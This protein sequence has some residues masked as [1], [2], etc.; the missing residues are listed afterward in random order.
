MISKSAS[1]LA[2]CGTG[3]ARQR[4]PEN[5]EQGVKNTTRNSQHVRIDLSLTNSLLIGHSKIDV[6]VAVV[7]WLH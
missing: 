2:L 5:P 4:G 1:G 7:I 3:I 6:R